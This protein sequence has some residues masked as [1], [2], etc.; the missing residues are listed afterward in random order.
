MQETAFISLDIY[1]LYVKK[2]NYSG[3]FRFIIYDMVET[4]IDIIFITSM[5]SYF[6]RNLNLEHF[7]AINQIFN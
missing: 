1:T 7:N 6:A 4:K 2:S 5:V 3:N